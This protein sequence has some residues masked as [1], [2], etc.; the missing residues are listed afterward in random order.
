MGAILYTAGGLLEYLDGRE[1]IGSYHVMPD[2][3][4]MAGDVHTGNEDIL[5][6]SAPT[7][8]ISEVAPL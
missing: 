8:I 5:K 2:G 4:P 1:Y 7:P 3:T 6:Y